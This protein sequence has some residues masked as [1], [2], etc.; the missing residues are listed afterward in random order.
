[1][2]DNGFWT[3]FC[4][5]QICPVYFVI[6]DHT[7]LTQALLETELLLCLWIWPKILSNQVLPDFWWQ[8]LL[9]NSALDTT[10]NPSRRWN[11]SYRQGSKDHSRCFAPSK[12]NQRTPHCGSGSSIFQ[13][14]EKLTS[15]ERTEQQT[16]Q[17]SSHPEKGQN[18]R[19][20]IHVICGAR[21][22]ATLAH[23]LSLWAYECCSPRKGLGSSLENVT[24]SIQICPPLHKKT[25]SQPR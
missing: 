16:L 4:W 9:R 25:H 13:S 21:C 12:E 6:R 10:E 2:T 14:A 24:W 1:M 8:T 11:E 22:S 5:L 7:Q 18:N 3:K 17:K 23:K 20:T 15:G 19:R